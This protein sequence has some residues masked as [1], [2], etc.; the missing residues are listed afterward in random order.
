MRGGIGLEHTPRP[1]AIACRS[2]RFRQSHLTNSAHIQF[3]VIL[4]IYL[5]FD[6]FNALA[7]TTFNKHKQKTELSLKAQFSRTKC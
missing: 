1:N 2:V 6:C 4:N 5:L 7:S 3:T